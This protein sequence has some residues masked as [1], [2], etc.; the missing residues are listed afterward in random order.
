MLSVLLAFVLFQTDGINHQGKCSVT[1]VK[2]YSQNVLGKNVGYFVEIKNESSSEVDAIEWE[3]VFCDEFDEVLESRFGKW[4]AGN[5]IQ[6]CKPGEIIQDV[7]PV[8]ISKATKV[9]IHI[10]RVHFTNGT[11]CGKKKSKEKNK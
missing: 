9:F 4:S 5:I 6:P 8:W 11:T 7:K 10:N 3:A 2:T 1:P